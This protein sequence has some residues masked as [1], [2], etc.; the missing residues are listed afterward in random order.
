MAGQASTGEVQNN[1]KDKQAERVD[2]NHVHPARCACGKSPGVTA[3]VQIDDQVGLRQVVPLLAFTTAVRGQPP[4]LVYRQRRGRKQH[5]QATGSVDHELNPIRTTVLL[6]PTTA[7]LGK[8]LPNLTG[9]NRIETFHLL[10]F[11]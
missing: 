7:V 3:G 5:Q 1:K 2:P 4:W 6:E 9:I 10:R 11:D 8:I